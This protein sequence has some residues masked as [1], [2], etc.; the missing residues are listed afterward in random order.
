MLLQLSNF[1]GL[2]RYKIT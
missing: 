1:E 2:K